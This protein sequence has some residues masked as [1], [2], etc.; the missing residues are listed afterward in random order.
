MAGGNLPVT[1]LI[2]GG[3]ITM[4][5][6]GISDP[7]NGIVG[8]IGRVLRGE[9]RSDALDPKNNGSSAADIAA[10][11]IAYQSPSGSSSGVSSAA[12]GGGGV[13]GAARSQIG[14]PYVWAGG[15]GGGPT[16]GG[17]DCSGLTQY[18][19][20]QGAGIDIPRVAEAQRVAA[21]TISASQ[22]KPGDLVFFGIPAYHVG[23][24]I[25]G[26]KMI[27]APHTGASVRVE[28]VSNVKP[29]PVTYGRFGGRTVAV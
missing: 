27:H 19:M 7:P 12:Y 3:G 24:Y 18:A 9:S 23:V 21:D 25:G 20:K 8:E 15:N 4:V 29:G 17:F 28:S 1:L 16:L 11:I 13:V 6:V 10:S 2:L 26:G 14:T 5:W 22:A